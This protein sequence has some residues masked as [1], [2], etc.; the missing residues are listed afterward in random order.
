M[1][2]NITRQARATIILTEKL[3]VCKSQEQNKTKSRVIDQSRQ[4]RIFNKNVIVNVMLSVQGQP[5]EC[6]V[7]DHVQD[8]H[9]RSRPDDDRGAYQGA[10]LTYN[11][12]LAFYQVHAQQ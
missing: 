9:H 4:I 5:K 6:R 10:A 7:K 1:F 12:L 8:H 3:A 2:V 11:D